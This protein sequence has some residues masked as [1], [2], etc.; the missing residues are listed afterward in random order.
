MKYFKIDGF[1]GKVFFC[2]RLNATLSP[3][4]CSRMFCQ[5]KGI[6]QPETSIA[7]CKGCPIGAEHSGSRVVTEVIPKNICIRCFKASSR[8]VKSMLCVSCANRQYEYLK[9]RNSQGN[10]PAKH[11]ELFPISVA[12]RNHDAESSWRMPFAVSI[13]E[14]MIA[15]IKIHGDGVVFGLRCS[16]VDAHV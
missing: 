4:S 2:Q 14:V 11:P 10:F 16:V 3:E 13:T 15:A 6:D 8:I 12:Y 5:A 1:K 9:G 7:A